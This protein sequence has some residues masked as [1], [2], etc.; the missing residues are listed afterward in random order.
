MDARLFGMAA[1][2]EAAWSERR[3]YDYGEVLE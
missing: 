3:V 1:K 2:D